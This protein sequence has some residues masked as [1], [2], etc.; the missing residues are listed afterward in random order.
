ML[1]MAHILHNFIAYDKAS[2][3]DEDFKAFLDEWV[4]G[5]KTH[6]EYLEKLGVNR[7][8]KYTNVPGFG[9]ATKV[10]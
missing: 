2:K 3:T 5:V 7:L 10:K 1:L 6:E 4:Y 9:Y 8:L